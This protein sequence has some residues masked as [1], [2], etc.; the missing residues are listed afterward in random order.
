MWFENWSPFFDV[1]KTLNEMDRVFNAVGRPLGL[2]SVPRGTFPAINV[3]DQGEA[4]VLTAEMPGV[5]IDDLELTVLGDSVTIKGHRKSEPGEDERFYRRERPMG[6]FS[7]T[8]TLPSPVNVDSVRAEYT[9]G[10]LRM[11]MD[12]AEAAKVHK[13]EIKS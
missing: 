7:R 13:V 1:E 9:D 4:A 10:V 11:H 5:N 8:V 6:E 2:R 12:K 3:Y